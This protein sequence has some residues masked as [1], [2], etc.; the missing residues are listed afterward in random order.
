M[1]IPLAGGSFPKLHNRDV[2]QLPHRCLNET[3]HDLAL[4]VVKASQARL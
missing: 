4:P 1:P 2:Q 3:A